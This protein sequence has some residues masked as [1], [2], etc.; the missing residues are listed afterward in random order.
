M[1][2]CIQRTIASTT[3]QIFAHNVLV[4]QILPHLAQYRGKLT[5]HDHKRI[6]VLNLQIWFRYIATAITISNF[7][8]NIQRSVFG[9]DKNLAE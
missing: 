6:I 1:F 7:E 2:D 4:F 8:I 9:D 5:V 3:D